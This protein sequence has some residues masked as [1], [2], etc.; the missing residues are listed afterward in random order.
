ME[1]IKEKIKK[2][3]EN[4]DWENAKESLWHL[5]EL[6]E[7]GNENFIELEHSIKYENKKSALANLEAIG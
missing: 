1:E 6:I 5:S 2:Y 7:Y 3:I 4:N